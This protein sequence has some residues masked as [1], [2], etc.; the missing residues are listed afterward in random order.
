M[1]NALRS[2]SAPCLSGDVLQ[3]A[4]YAILVDG[5]YLTKKLH[6]R[7]NRAATA[8]DVF[9]ECERL[10]GIPEV[11]EYELLRIYYYDAYPSSESAPMP[12]SG[13][14][15]ALGET[16]RFRRS[17]QLF[18]ALIM[19]PHMALRMGS[20][21][22]SPQK[23]KLKHQVADALKATPR[24]LTD[25]DF[26]LDATQKGVDIR[27]GMDMARLA[28]R[29]MVRAVVVVTGD[30]DFVPAFKYVRREGVKV[31]LEPMGNNGRIEL[32][33]HA[34]IVLKTPRRRRQAAPVVAGQAAA[35]EVT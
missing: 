15:H 22:L 9:A 5:G 12:V 1:R 8:D 20:V 34:D 32:R 17:Q 2:G 24:P 27:I 25:N 6:Q 13:E 30:S 10:S 18:D 16:E 35:D 29:E 19:K 26:S 23:W 11:Q 7:N 28:L 4:L 33:Q 14:A 21:S 3:K 31:I